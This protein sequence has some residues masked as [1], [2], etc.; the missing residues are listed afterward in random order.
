MKKRE[1]VKKNSSFSYKDCSPLFSLSLFVPLRSF[2]SVV[3]ACVFFILNMSI[4]K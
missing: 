2:L 1:V 3:L 4:L